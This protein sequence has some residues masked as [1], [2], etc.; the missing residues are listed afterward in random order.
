[1]SL[2]ISL[3]IAVTILFACSQQ[4]THYAVKTEKNWRISSPVSDAE[5]DGQS[6][7][8]YDA[9]VDND[10][11]HAVYALTADHK[12]KSAYIGY[13]NSVD[14]GEHWSN[15]I[16]INS[17]LELPVESKFGND[18]QIAA[19]GKDLMVVWQTSGE[20]PGMGPLFTVYSRDGGQS[21][22]QGENPS[23]DNVNT[24]QSHADIAADK[25]GKFHLVWLDDR[26]E[27]GFQGLR[28]AR[29]GDNG[30]HWEFAQTIDDSSCSCCWNRLAVAENGRLEALYRDMEFRDMALAQSDDAGQSWRLLGRVG[31]FNWKFDGC[32]HN[33][34]GLA[35]TAAGILHSSV[36]TGAE[37]KQGLY[38]LNSAD[39][40]KHWS[41]PRLLGNNAF[42]SDI[43]AQ[44]EE[45][46]AVIWDAMG[47]EGS[48]VY[49]SRS[50]NNGQDWS[51]PS[52]LSA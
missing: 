9:Y 48:G 32:P 28:Y 18:I 34:G 39:A 47:P 50:A 14:G 17:K 3:L 1:M 35:I 46:I 37:N 5:I 33:G 25:Q 22:K 4:T 8:S 24:D 7:S 6:L 12:S 20:I 44:D 29:S 36:W 41:A 2:H 38:Y 11:I 19:Y 31:E 27:N 51:A 13:V 16:A 49:T 45:Q 30:R 42:H 43:A 15:P 40:G 21:W 10:T 26:N 52:K 23:G